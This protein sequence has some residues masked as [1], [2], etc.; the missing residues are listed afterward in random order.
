MAQNNK[1]NRIKIKIRPPKL[2]FEKEN[3]FDM[4]LVR[5]PEKPKNC[6]KLEPLNNSIP[7]K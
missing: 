5:T 6:D 1:T 2:H 4:K 3:V 7:Q